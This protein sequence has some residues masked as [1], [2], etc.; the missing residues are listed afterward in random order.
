MVSSAPPRWAVKQLSWYAPR[1]PVFT[2][3]NEL[4]LLRGGTQLFPAM[5]SAIERARHEVWLASYIFNDDQEAG[6]VVAALIGAA[7]R[8][9]SVRVVVDG[10]GSVHCLNRPMLARLTAA[11]VSVAVFRRA[12]SW[13][14]WLKPGQLRRLHMKLCVVDGE[15]GFVGG[16]NLMSDRYDLSHGWT[17]EPRLDYAVSV[18]GAVV[19]PIEQTARAMW[20]RSWFGHDWRG[21]IGSFIRNLMRQPKRVARMRRLVSRMRLRLD[22]REARAFSLAVRDA[23]P[24]RAAFLVRDNLRQ[25]RTIERTYI[26][27][28]NAASERVILVTPYFYPG[29]AFRHALRSA[30]R[31]GV[32]VTLLLQGKLDYRFAG[33]AARVLYAEML[34]AGVHIWEYQAAFL[35]AKVAIVDDEWATVGSS[36]ID[37]LSLLVNLEANVVVRDA[38]FVAELERQLAVDFAGATEVLSFDDRGWALRGL[39]ALV[40]WCANIY[41]RIA[42]V[43]GPY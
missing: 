13:W 14:S 8:G 35:H 2:G 42:G 30:A 21:G 15:I 26:D 29:V 16:I 24:V 28:I 27:A 33:W 9:V 5:C 36:N 7:Q 19:G 37:P 43:N 10:W 1:R 11:G 18:R 38:G 22:D 6:A 34:H 4:R 12:E 25:R 3:G 23:Q 31:R 20:T 17:D 32:Q 41:L 39:R 40:A